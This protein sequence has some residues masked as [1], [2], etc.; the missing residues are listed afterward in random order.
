MEQW[1]KQQ[2]SRKLQFYVCRRT[3]PLY[4]QHLKHTTNTDL[5]SPNYRQ[6]W[7][8][9]ARRGRGWWC[10]DT[11][12]Q[13]PRRI[14]R[15]SSA[16]SSYPYRRWC[17]HRRWARPQLHR[18]CTRSSPLGRTAAIQCRDDTKSADFL[19]FL[20]SDEENTWWNTNLFIPESRRIPWWSLYQ[21]RGKGR[22]NWSHGLSLQHRMC[23]G[24][25]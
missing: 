17:T 10:P 19:Y 1:K 18:S 5:I 11:K 14:R 21:Q 16:L 2:P 25:S 6:L 13:R 7:R 8:M 20:A 15:T 4:K 22:E 24:S 3:W 9:S 23:R 12:Q